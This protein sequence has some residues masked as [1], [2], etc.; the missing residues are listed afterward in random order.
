MISLFSLYNDL[1]FLFFFFSLVKTFYSFFFFYEPL[2][3][4]ICFIYTSTYI[5]KIQRGHIGQTWLE[6]CKGRGF[7]VDNTSKKQVWKAPF[8]FGNRLLIRENTLKKVAAS[9]LETN[10]RLIIGKILGYLFL[11]NMVATPK[12][13]DTRRLNQV[14]EFQ[15]EVDQE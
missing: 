7:F 10:M 13:V 5:P 2:W 3:F 14:F 11:P 9:K 1:W 8:L 15:K 12:G 6:I 4:L